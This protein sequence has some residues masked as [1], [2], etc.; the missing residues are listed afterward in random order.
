MVQVE[1]LH[2]YV[3]LKMKSHNQKSHFVADVLCRNYALFKNLHLLV[4]IRLGVSKALKWVL[5]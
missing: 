1:L 4:E 5:I 2:Y 3:S